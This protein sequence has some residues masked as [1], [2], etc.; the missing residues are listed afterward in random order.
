VILI[1][2]VLLLCDTIV[3]ALFLPFSCSTNARVPLVVLVLSRALLITSEADRIEAIEHVISSMDK[4]V[5]QEAVIESG[6]ASE[7]PIQ[8]RELR[9][10]SIEFQNELIETEAREAEERRLRVEEEEAARVAAEEAAK[11]AEAAQKAA[12]EALEASKFQA[13]NSSYVIR[14]TAESTSFDAEAEKALA[15]DKEA[16]E[17]QGGVVVD[18]TPE[19]I[20]AIEAL[21]SGSAVGPEREKLELIRSKLE[22]EE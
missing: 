19:E 15:E 4:E 8:E 18:L 11:L 6:A 3:P 1:S 12:E 5:I 14:S 16:I 20:E 13:T 22:S 10:A 21:A 17:Q 2:K 9:L 7:D